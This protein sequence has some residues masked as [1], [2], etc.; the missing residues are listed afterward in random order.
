[1]AG[2]GCPTSDTSYPTPA[3]A[4][5]EPKPSNC[6]AGKVTTPREAVEPVTVGAPEVA[7]QLDDEGS[8]LWPLLEQSGYERW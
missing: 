4:K 6:S 7:V 8:W 3:A 2:V 5:K 1:M